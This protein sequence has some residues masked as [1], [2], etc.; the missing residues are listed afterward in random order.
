M[1][2]Q[3][4]WGFAAVFLIVVAQAVVRM[5]IHFGRRRQWEACLANAVIGLM[6][7]GTAVFLG[8]KALGS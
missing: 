8:S 3:L 5:S 4:L 7:T 2:M 6:L 1:M